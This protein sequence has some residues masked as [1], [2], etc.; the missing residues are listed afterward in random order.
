MSDGVTELLPNVTD[1]AY[2]FREVDRPPVS[3]YVR[4]LSSVYLNYSFSNHK[5]DF[6]IDCDWFKKLLFSTNSLAKLLSDSLLL[7]S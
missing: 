1:R 6:F 5:N 2:H 7:D 3:T 4:C